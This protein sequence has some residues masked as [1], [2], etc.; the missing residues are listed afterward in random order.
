[1]EADVAYHRSRYQRCRGTTDAVYRAGAPAWLHLPAR[2]AAGRRSRSPAADPVA[3]L[4]SSG[5]EIAAERQIAYDTLVVATGS[6]AN[7]FNTPGVAEHCSTIDSRTQALRFNDR[8]REAL[9]RSLVDRQSVEL[10]IVGGGATGVELSAE[11][12]RLAEIGQY[13]GAEGLIEAVNV[14]LVESADSLLKAFPTEVST[15]ATERLRVLGVTV[16]TGARGAR[17][18]ASSLEMTDGRSLPCTLCAWAAGVKGGRCLAKWAWN[19]RAPARSWST[20]GFAGAPTRRSSRSATALACRYRATTRPPPPTAQ[21][22]AR[23]AKYLVRWL[24]TLNRG[25]SAPAFR[26]QDFASKT[27]VP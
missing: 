2:R 14:H 16:H 22:A 5:A 23:Q 8:V 24:T 17:C 18:H 27:S 7:D 1:M 9:F 25:G 26:F 6:Q 13:Y 15:S 11:L 3:L 19:C 10:V 4:G 12:I 20:T 21:A